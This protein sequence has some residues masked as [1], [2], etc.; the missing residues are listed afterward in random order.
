MKRIPAI[1]LFL[2]AFAPAC[3]AVPITG[4]V[5]GP[6]TAANDT[7]SSTS[8]DV[9]RYTVGTV[10]SIAYAFDPARAFDDGGGSYRIPSMTFGFAT[11]DGLSGSGRT[12]DFTPNAVRVID[13]P[14]DRVRIEIGSAS[15]FLV[16]SFSDPSGLAIASTALPT[17][18]D[19]LRFPAV[20]VQM[21]RERGTGGD[22]FLAAAVPVP[23]T[24]TFPVPEPSTLALG[25]AGAG[26]IGLTRGRRR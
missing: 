15:A 16:L 14:T 21:D 3:R 5:Q 18:A 11:S 22:Q 2:M 26:L 23:D 1:T 17:I 24:S 25:L 4:Y 9:Q 19:L 8:I 13:G 7:P 10:A 20:A 12:A 6:I